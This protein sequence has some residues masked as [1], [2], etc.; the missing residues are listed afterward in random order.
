MKLVVLDFES[1]DCHIY[2]ITSEI[3]DNEEAVIQFICDNNHSLEN[4]HY[5]YGEV[6]V[7]HDK[8]LTIR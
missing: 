2:T 5:M 4:C 7:Y 3:A 8:N 6:A 1:G